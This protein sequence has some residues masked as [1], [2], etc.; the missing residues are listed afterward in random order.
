MKPEA[1]IAIYAAVV[2]T[3]ALLLNFRSWLDSRPRLHL[4]L[5]VDGMTIGG[6]SAFDE[7]DLTILTVTNRGKEPTMITN[8]VVFKM[9]SWYERWRIRPLKSYVIP[10]PQLKGY[11]HNI[12][13]DLEPSKKWVGALRDR[14]D[15]LPHLHNG[16]YYVGVYAS[17]RDRPYLK[18][19]PKKKNKLPENAETLKD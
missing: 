14:P 5:M 16:T 12:P 4:S 18:L 8:M 3:S 15:V 1:W 6:G 10:N 19:I 13:S 7:K 11:P 2:A 9:S 17:H